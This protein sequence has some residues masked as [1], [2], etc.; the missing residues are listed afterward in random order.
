MN[1]AELPVTEVKGIGA[2]TAKQL[3]S[4]NIHSIDD[5]LH[6]FPFRYE[7]LRI[8]HLSE[9]VHEE[10]ITVFGTVQTTPSLRF[11]GKNKSRLTFRMLVNDISI[12][13]TFFN[14]AFLKDKI[15]PGVELT[16]TGKWD[17]HRLALTGNE[18]HFGKLSN[19]EAMKPVY[20]I[21]GSLTVKA[22]QRYIAQALKQF[23]PYVKDVL[24]QSLRAL[25]KLPTKVDALQWL[26]FPPNERALKHARRRL[27]YEELFI[28][29][30]K[31]Q[32]FRKVNRERGSSR[33]LSFSEE[34]VEAFIAQLP[35][36]LTNAQ[37]RVVAEILHD[38]RS[39]YQMNRLL[40]GDVGSGKTIV[41]AI[42]MYAV[43]QAGYQAALMVPTEILAEQHV[44]SLIEVFEP[45]GVDV[46]LLTS[47]VKGKKREDVLERLQTGALPLVVGTH[48][49][50][51]DDVRFQKLGLVITDEQH[52]FGVEQ[53]RL[54]KEKGED[55]NVLFMTATPIPRTLAI[56]MFGD[57]DVSVID[58]LPRGRKQI[59]TYWAR[60]DMFPRVLEF[61]E[62]E[63]EKG[64][65]A[66][67]ICPL[68]EESD[69]LDVQNAIDI[70]E[71]LQKHYDGKWRIGLM[72]GR[73]HPT[74]KE[75]VMKSFSDHET[76]ILVS[77][78]VVEVGVNVPNA[79]VIVVYDA[80]RFG[81][82]QLHQLRGRVG[83][84][85]HQSYC[86]LIADPKTEVGKERMQIMTETT[87][88][89]RLAEYDLKLRGPGEFFGLKQ[90]GMP[91]F[92]IADLVRDYRALEVARRDAL[93]CVESNA[94][95]NG[96][97]FKPLRDYME[98]QGVFERQKLD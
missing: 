43:V 30:L 12:S 76:D 93:K 48:A 4:L 85:R 40:Q 84:G 1:L 72:H 97:E 44:Q 10:R 57:M 20:S 63:L 41:A 13:V 70:Y 29:Q 95:W 52:R 42:C 37:R 21:S 83:R 80:D 71:R 53:R 27:I 23:S 66:Y 22:M 2:E 91:E 64:R 67:V 55:V 18:C 8:T 47:S 90:S 46:K 50:I 58:E 39:P 98:A 92:K 78:T 16:V 26:H 60:H 28:F 11:L 3:A 61:V 24:P 31:M 59:E 5:L 14:R 74:E 62:K 96:D 6:H 68:I 33:P 36:P 15:K 45:F 88:G 32:L 89:F 82:A 79:T 35:F 56:S 54:L 87:D 49:L 65:Q 38:L 17:A 75:A 86:I 73:L 51:Q 25:Y 94:F 34:K 9:A 7:S 77:T 81:L 69:K 19:E